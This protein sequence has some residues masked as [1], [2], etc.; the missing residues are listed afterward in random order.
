MLRVDGIDLVIAHLRAE[1]QV[2]ACDDRF[3]VGERQLRASLSAAMDGS[4]PTE[5]VMPFNTR[6]APE[7]AMALTACGPA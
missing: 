3:L 6:S 5:P 4:S 1:K 2:T 7:P